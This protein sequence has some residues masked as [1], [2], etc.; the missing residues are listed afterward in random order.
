MEK[1]TNLNEA[2]EVVE[3]P[4]EPTIKKRRGRRSNA[5]IAAAKELNP[6]TAPTSGESDSTPARKRGRRKSNANAVQ[7]VIGIHKMVSMLPGMEIWA[8]DEAEAQTITEA[9]ALVSEEYGVQISGK[10]GAT[11]N[12]IMALGMV[13]GPRAYVMIQQSKQRKKELALEN[14]STPEVAQ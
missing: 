11:L 7:Q 10:T 5:E 6:E 3:V 1:A 4:T 14:P 2:P 12:L 9:M 8:I 13:Y